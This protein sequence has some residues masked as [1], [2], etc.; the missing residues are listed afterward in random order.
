MIWRDAYQASE[1]H[2]YMSSDK[3]EVDNAAEG[4][5][6]GAYV[7]TFTAGEANIYEPSSLSGTVYWRVDAV[8]DGQIVK[9]NTWK[10]M[11][12]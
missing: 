6:T 11:V 1:H 3:D 12:N 7:D 2:L 4:S 8:V 5:T 10:F 9:G